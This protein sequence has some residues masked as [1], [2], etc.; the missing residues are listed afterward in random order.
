MLRVLETA[1]DEMRLDL[2][3]LK[4]LLEKVSDEIL[5][6]AVLAGV[7]VCGDKTTLR[8]G[9]D[10]DVTLGDDDETAPTTRILDVVVR[11]GKNHGLHQ[12]AHAESVANL[13]ESRENRLLAVEAFRVAA[14]AVNRDVLAEVGCH[15][16]SLYH[17]KKKIGSNACALSPIN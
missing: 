12:R 7:D 11:C 14:V 1:L 5:V 6:H 17:Q 9:V 3:E 8:E 4:L 15:R 10:T 2:L 13:S 16:T